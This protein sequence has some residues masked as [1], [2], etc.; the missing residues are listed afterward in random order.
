MKSKRL[1]AIEK[2]IM[3]HESVSMKE[4]RDYF[5]VSMNTVRRDVVELLKRGTVRK[6][7]GGVCAQTPESA[8]IPYEVRSGGDSRQKEAVCREAVRFVHDGDVIFIDSGTTTV[9]LMDYLKNINNLTVVTNNVEVIMKALDNENISLIALPGQ[10]LHKTRSV[11]GETTVSFL[12]RYNIRTAFMAATGVS[13]QGVTNSS[14]L[15]YEIK[16]KALENSEIKVLM[17]TGRKF[18]VTGLM[19]YANIEQFDVIITDGSIPERYRELVE[20]KHVNLV[21]AKEEK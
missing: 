9:W 14:P 12:A 18:G 6:V 13:A 20:N 17:V 19:T 8:L 21:I 2:Y 10:L 11:T 5:K 7:Y 16:K 3:D 4:L 1:I 15:E